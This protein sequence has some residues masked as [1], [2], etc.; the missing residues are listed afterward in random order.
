MR[1]KAL[2]EIYTI[3]LLAEAESGRGVETGGMAKEH[4]GYL[5]KTIC[6]I[7]RNQNNSEISEPKKLVLLK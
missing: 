7:S 6:R 5:Q 2:A 1:L 4:H 3:Y